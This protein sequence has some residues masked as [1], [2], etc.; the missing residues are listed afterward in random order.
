MAAAYASAVGE[1]WRHS[2][3][4]ATCVTPS[5][6]RNGRHET[7][8]VQG[9]L[10]AAAAACLPSCR[11]VE[12]SATCVTPSC[13]KGS[14][15]SCTMMNCT[16]PV[17]MLVMILYA[18]PVR[19]VWHSAGSATESLHPAGEHKSTAYR[20]TALVAAAC[21]ACCRRESFSR[22]LQLLPRATQFL[23]KLHSEVLPA[24]QKL[25]T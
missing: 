14:K 5:C 10:H 4:S 7:A 12:R 15:M 9:D 3:G 1:M 8:Q 20:H 16:L 18:S 24:A 6:T 19:E 25:T 11:H 23:Q 2:A 13:K 22:Q 17:H 21:L